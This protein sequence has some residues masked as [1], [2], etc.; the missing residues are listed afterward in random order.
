M[1]RGLLWA[2]ENVVPDTRDTLAALDRRLAELRDQIA[3][4]A[5]APAPA[6]P[7][8]PPTPRPLPP[9][10]AAGL[11]DDVPDAAQA[12]HRRA[13]GRALVEGVDRLGSEIEELLRMRERLLVEARELL[14]RYQLQL[15]ALAA[16]DPADIRAAVASLLS[17]EPA[18]RGE[19]AAR[20][21]PGPRPAFFEGV[22]TM[23]VGGATRIQTIQVLEDSLSRILHVERV[24]IRRWHAG[25]LWLEL[26]LSDGVELLGELNRVLPFPFAVQ[27]ATGQEIVISLEGER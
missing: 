16:E 12:E 23:T 2:E 24:Y 25:A 20:S 1:S 6:P 9:P 19:E 5:E 13:S 15:D 18:A 11:A 27:S 3:D 14:N 7:P 10:T 8:P 4:L 17:P 22:V 26:S 21:E